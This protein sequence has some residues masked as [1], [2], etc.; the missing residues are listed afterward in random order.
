M[1]IAIDTGGTFTDVVLYD[2][3]EKIF[4][5]AKISSHPIHPE[6][7][8]MEGLKNV[9]AGA[10]GALTAG[11]D[12]VHGTTIVTNALLEGKTARVGLLVT[13]GFRDLMEIGRQHRPH[14]YNLMIDRKPPLVSRDGVRE[15]KERVSSEKTILLPLDEKD[16]EKQIRALKR[17]GSQVLAIVLL[18]S[19]LNPKH[20]NRLEKLAQKYFPKNHIFPSSRLSPE[21]REFERAST[22]VV[23]AAVAPRVIDYIRSLDKCLKKTRSAAE[24]LRIMHSGGGTVPPE[25]AMRAPHTLIESGPAAG[26]IGASHL[27]KKMSLNKV[28][29]FDMG[30][31]TAKAGLILNGALQFSQEYEVGGEFHHAGRQRGSG[32]PI[33]APMIDVVECGAGAGSIAWIDEGGH[34]KVGPKSAGADPGPACYG[35]GGEKPTVT[36]A[37]V[38]LGRITADSFLG[39]AMPLH[40]RYSRE[41][42]M[43]SVGR[44]LN[45]SL[46]SAARGILSVAN[47]GML[48]IIWLI[49]V[50]RGY[51]PRDFTLMACGGAGPLHAVEL[52]EKMSIRHVVIPPMAGLFSTLG[53]LFADTSKDFV[54]TAML[55]LHAR[56]LLNRHLFRLTRQADTWFEKNHIPI[57][58]RKI[59]YSADLRYINQNYELILPLP[60]PI[61]GKED[62]PALSDRF[63]AMHEKTYG[64]CAPGEKIQ[65][66]NLR[67]RATKKSPKP[68]WPKRTGPIPD[69]KYVLFSKQPVYFTDKKFESR[70]Y[71][72]SRIPSDRKLKGPAV[73]RERE[74]TTLVGPSWSFR[75]DDLDELHLFKD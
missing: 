15:V 2:P 50:A 60:G 61:I 27:A 49:S 40:P 47:A 71:D 57:R 18:F 5:T 55:S 70:I 4:T 29:A 51:D 7:P 30:G 9:L 42:I 48:R 10:R 28:I 21:F 19:F 31:T 22:T 8:F 25:E 1:R 36:D 44:P 68:D 67:V 23:S 20:E 75:V 66:V 41:A 12:I 24:T 3:V 59:D 56:A 54:K 73:I 64:H 43:E 62:L 26:L 13:R 32:Y 35:K 69:S 33:R 74:S 11:D 58:Q 38:V 46:E 16:A 53:L 14:L 63:H 72:R 34:L 6:I 37:H 65:A 52:A 17:N 45:L 39:G